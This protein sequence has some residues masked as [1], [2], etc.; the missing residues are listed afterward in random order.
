MRK[1]EPIAQND[2]L[3]IR[4]SL[5]SRMPNKVPPQIESPKLPIVTKLDEK[6]LS[7]TINAQHSG[8]KNKVK[9]ASA[10]ETKR[11]NKTKKILEETEINFQKLSQK[12][13]PR[14]SKNKKSGIEYFLE[15]RLRKY[16]TPVISISKFERLY[17]IKDGSIISF[18]AD[19]GITKVHSDPFTPEIAAEMGKELYEIYSERKKQQSAREA[20]YASTNTKM[21][22]TQ[23]NYYKLIFTR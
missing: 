18:L 5:A 15:I 22:K 6:N 2:L 8:V 3:A 11:L 9:K 7:R 19:K 1:S 21:P 12:T 4:S 13:K 23:P 14:P 17:F 16:Y 20:Y 10:K